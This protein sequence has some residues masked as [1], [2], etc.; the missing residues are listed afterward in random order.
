MINH[1]ILGFDSSL[2]HTGSHYDDFE[3]DSGQNDE[4]TDKA[5]IGKPHEACY[6]GEAYSATFWASRLLGDK[7]WSLSLSL[8]LSLL[9]LY[10]QQRET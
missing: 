1:L 4:G 8:S 9:V 6:P 2:S 3:E 10:F 7:L 5:K